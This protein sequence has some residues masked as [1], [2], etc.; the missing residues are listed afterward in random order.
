MSIKI[1]TPDIY[2]NILITYKNRIIGSVVNS[3]KY[4]LDNSLEAI[5]N[6]HINNLLVD[7]QPVGSG[8]DSDPSCI[9]SVLPDSYT[10]IFST[11]GKS[12][13]GGYATV[14][15][16]SPIYW[17]PTELEITASAT[18][19]GFVDV[20][21]PGL[22]LHIYCG[23]STNLLTGFP[24]SAQYTISN[25]T[26]IYCNLNYSIADSEYQWVF[27]FK[28]INNINIEVIIPLTINDI[29]TWV[30]KEFTNNWSNAFMFINNAEY[31]GDT[32]KCNYKIKKGIVF[33]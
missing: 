9:G 32:V 3:N 25:S 29:I 27:S 18:H 23:G 22:Y 13:G 7:S 24:G 5:K 17:L 11:K 21:T 31:S 14:Y 1:K 16:S 20:N 28:D 19:Q 30:R 26:I 6:G 8:W 33:K 12:N 2:K 10:F 15:S 4:I